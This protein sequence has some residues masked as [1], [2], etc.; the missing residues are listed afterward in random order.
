MP[1]VNVILP[2]SH[3]E[4][5]SLIPE[6]YVGN[7]KLFMHYTTERLVEL[8]KLKLD[9]NVNEL[10]ELLERSDE[11]LASIHI[12]SDDYHKLITVK[13]QLSDPSINTQK[14]NMKP[15]LEFKTFPRKNKLTKAHSNKEG[16]LS[17]VYK[18]FFH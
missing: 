1:S 15:V 18:R 8:G 10:A 9:L 2:V 7:P 12:W 3:E 6:D 13:A 17:K 5:M 14:P 4:F 11:D 16:L